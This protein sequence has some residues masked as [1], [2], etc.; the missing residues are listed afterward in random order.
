MRNRKPEIISLA[1]AVLAVLVIAGVL[2]RNHIQ[3][4]EM[5]R[6]SLVSQGNAILTALEGGMRFHR[7]LGGWFLMNIGDVMEETSTA[8]EIIGLAVYSLDGKL[9]ASG[10]QV[11]EELPFDDQAQWLDEGLAVSRE[12]V[13]PFD[14]EDDGD[15]GYRGGR[16][17]MMGGGYMDPAMLEQLRKPMRLFALMDDQAFHAARQAKQIQFA[18]LFAIALIAIAMGLASVWMIQRQGRLAAELRL[19]R[20]HQARLEEMTEL[21]AGLAH[22]TKNPLSLIRGQAQAWLRALEADD[23]GAAAAMN[24][25]DETDRLVGRINGFLKYTRPVEPVLAPVDACALLNETM[26]LF[27]D[28]ARARSIHLETQCRDGCILAD[29]DMM[30]Q[31][32]VNL[33]TN[34]LA[35]C[36]ESNLI[37]V[38]LANT[39]KGRRALIVEDTGIGIAPE[40]LPRAAHPYFSRTEGGS[41]LGLSIISRIVAAHQWTMAIDSK[42]G[43]GTSV[44]IGNIREG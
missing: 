13:L 17:M 33:V 25:I 29:E 18:L 42:P 40:D 28:E 5:L 19:S 20:E 30:R 44:T 34:A 37:K 16:G 7:R 22:E 24:I 1:S 21:A 27:E 2:W 6:Q 10:G 4:L 3:D 41:G 11:P 35:A 43:A 12:F 23:S 39:H 38:T 8:P 9:L 36:N 14:Q 26:A 15:G 32:I 31:I